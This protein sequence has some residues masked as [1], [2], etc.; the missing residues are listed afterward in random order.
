[1][2]MRVT[3]GLPNYRTTWLLLKHLKGLVQGLRLIKHQRCLWMPKDHGKLIFIHSDACWSS[4]STA[5]RVWG[6]L[7]AG[8]ITAKVCGTCMVAPQPPLTLD[9]PETYRAVFEKCTW[10]QPA[11]R[12]TAI[13]V[14]TEL[15]K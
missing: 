2:H 4:L 9:V 13:Q 5:N 7:D 6:E 12:P 1:M 8:Q 3:W 10:L 14:L 11:E 15:D